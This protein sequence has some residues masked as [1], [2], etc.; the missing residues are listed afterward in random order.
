[1]PTI[2]IF[3]LPCFTD[4]SSDTMLENQAFID[5]CW[6]S[7]IITCDICWN[8]IILFLLL[9]KAII[10]KPEDHKTQRTQDIG[11]TPGKNPTTR[12]N[13]NNP[14]IIE[15]DQNE[16]FTPRLNTPLKVP[17]QPSS[18]VKVKYDQLTSINWRYIQPSSNF[19]SATRVSTLLPTSSQLRL[20]TFEKTTRCFRFPR[21]YHN[22]TGN[23]HMWKVKYRTSVFLWF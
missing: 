22:V 21:P 1:M 10:K 6:F 7:L 19:T 17:R 9:H 5:L 3:K 16:I 18:Q 15:S 12:E 20:L 4:L 8:F 11:S 13:S 2:V 14:F 23:L